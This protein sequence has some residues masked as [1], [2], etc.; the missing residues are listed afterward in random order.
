M[1]KQ[2]GSSCPSVLDRSPGKCGPQGKSL[3]QP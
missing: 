3:T 2:G 1:L